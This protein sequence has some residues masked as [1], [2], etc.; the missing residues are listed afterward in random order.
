M[1]DYYSQTELTRLT[2][3]RAEDVNAQF[4]GVSAGFDKLPTAARFKEHRIDYAADTGAANA[5]VVTLAPVPTAYVVGMTIDLVAANVNTGA[6]TINVNG[7]GTKQILDATG[8]ALAAGAIPAGRPVTLKYDGTSFRILAI[9]TTSTPGSDTIVADMIADPELKAIAGLTSAADKLPY[10]TGSGTAALADLNSDARTL[11]TDATNVP[12]K[13]ASATISGAWTFGTAVKISSAANHRLTLEDSDAAADKKMTSL[14]NSDGS[15]SISSRTDADA[16]GAFALRCIRGTGTAWDSIEFHTN[17]AQ[18]GKFDDDGRLLIGPSDYTGTDVTDIGCSIQGAGATAPGA[19]ST[20]VATTAGL[21]INRQTDDGNLVE[22]YQGGTFEGAISVSGTTIT[23]GSFC[24]HHWSQLTDN[25]KPAIKRGT[26]VE[27]IDE[28]C[29]WTG[30]G[31][32]QLAKFKI[33]DTEASTAVYGVFMQWDEEDEVNNDAL[34][35]A[36]GAFII[37][38]KSGETVAKGDLIESA[39]NGC[40]QVQADGIVRSSTV[41]KVTA[42]VTIETFEDG[43]YLVPCVLYSG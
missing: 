43:S 20:T 3:A 41:A 2:L 22:L 30:E 1:S 10:F 5:Y 12:R 32:D 4:S 17:G 29:E 24:G 37:R 23:Y 27:T 19:I 25:S 16:F 13:N 15:F 40:G 33:S 38:I 6:S 42:S 9:I 11:L 8:A 21:F 7:L 14:S 35:A 39:G 31:N 34:I 36:L 26:I 28:M 18:V